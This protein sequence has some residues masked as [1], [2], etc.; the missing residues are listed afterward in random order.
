MVK[1]RLKTFWN[2]TIV[3]A[4]NAILSVQCINALLFLYYF[5]YQIYHVIIILKTAFIVLYRVSGSIPDLPVNNIQISFP[6][7]FQ[8]Y[9]YYS[10]SFTKA[11]FQKRFSHLKTPCSEPQLLVK[12]LDSLVN[13]R[14]LIKWLKWDPKSKTRVWTAEQRGVFFKSDSPHAGVLGGVVIQL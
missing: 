9:P 14:E 2:V 3:P 6:A 7:I 10:K 4:L 5:L 8:T 11:R 12:W 13:T 1:L